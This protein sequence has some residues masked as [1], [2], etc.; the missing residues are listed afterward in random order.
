MAFVYW[1]ID[2]TVRLRIQIQ[3]VV[4]KTLIDKISKMVGSNFISMDSKTLSDR[5]IIFLENLPVMWLHFLVSRPIFDE[6][7]DDI[8]EI[9]KF[10]IWL[11]DE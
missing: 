1:K 11:N 10:L 9:Q 4:I 7:S 2:Y 5:K 6:E 8:V 3:S